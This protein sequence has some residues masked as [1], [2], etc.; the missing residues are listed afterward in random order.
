MTDHVNYLPWSR[1][2]G[3]ASDALAVRAAG[4]DVSVAVARFGP[5]DVVGLG[6]SEV[7]RREPPAGAAGFQPNLFAFVEF[8]AADLP[9]RLTPGGPDARGRLR[10]WLALLVLPAPDGSPV[11]AGGGP[12]PVVEVAAGDLP[13]IDEIDLWAHVQLPADPQTPPEQM[14]ATRGDRALSRVVSPRVLLPRTRYVACLVPTFEAGR[15]AGVGD[16]VGDPSSAT[17][18]WGAGDSA[19]VRLP[20]YESWIFSTAE[21]GDFETLARR[22]T[23][24]DLS[25]ASRPWPLD[26]AMITGAAAGRVVPFDT[27]L[28]PW[29][30]TD[31]W[32]APARTAAHDRLRRW[33]RRVEDASADVPAIGPPLYGGMA[34]AA[35]LTEPGWMA[36][37]NLDPRRRAAA[38]LGA[39]AV[40]RNQ[41]DLVADAWTQLGDLRRANRERDVAAIAGL[42]TARLVARNIAALAPEAV[43]TVAA[44]LL[45]RRK[46]GG[47]AALDTVAASALPA[48]V[49]SPAFR[50]LAAVK[51]PAGAPVH[52]AFIA[53]MSARV[54][55]QG[56]L[57]PA[58]GQLL[59]AARARI[60]LSPGTHHPPVHPPPV[61]PP[62]AHP[63]VEPPPAHPPP[64]HPPPVHPPPLPPPHV[65]PRVVAIEA[66]VARLAQRALTRVEVSRQKAFPFAAVGVSVAQ[67]LAGY[68]SASRRLAARLDLGD[69][70][71][72][73]RPTAPL[74]G[75]IDVPWP[76][77]GALA[78]MDARYLMSGIAMPADTVGLLQIN[79][80]FVTA[81]LVGANHELVRELTWRGAKVDRRATPL[82]RFFDRR[83]TGSSDPDISPVATWPL[84]DALPAHFALTGRAV[85]VLRG[86]LVRRFPNAGVHAAHAVK[87]GAIRSPGSEVR[88]PLFRGS[89][90]EDTM[91]V[92]F[93][94]TPETMRGTDGLGWYVVITEQPAAPRFGLD[95]PSVHDLT[96][97]NDVAW[98]DVATA[99]GYVSAAGR[100][101]VP[102][103]PAGLVWN[104]DAA[105]MAGITFQRLVAI[106]MHAADML[107]RL[108]TEPH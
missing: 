45:A 59:T 18:A 29:G 17:P 42:V 86:E 80:G 83:G 22:L 9:W 41:E 35:P 68:R 85:I 99:N 82:S 57:P 10:P 25:E 66:G 105:H 13:S 70:G 28:V 39:E 37:L 4:Q 51:A 31:M 12:L 97:W 5:G 16:D 65:D 40:R 19:T 44:P 46:S 49:L 14:L 7:L 1:R 88:L 53:R 94:L 60:A 93:D 24:R 43:L 78:A 104:R 102:A 50:R 90:T 56:A 81:V 67:D 74:V 72:D 76:L 6:P 38:A 84:A 98:N 58:P 33:L 71:R 30:A 26:L 48:A 3:L 36:E 107:L 92:G 23:P 103:Q 69:V 47:V 52:P 27:A 55:A 73:V 54:P 91:F 106:A 89:I 8:R 79:A 101:P 61:H 34:A 32:Q 95:E 2:A 21:A 77:T 15:R 75:A 96:T 87:Q 64:V 63:P 108:Q 100:T 11:V 20:V 62:P